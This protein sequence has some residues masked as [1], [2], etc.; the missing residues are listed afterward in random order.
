M[1]LV[2]LSITE[3]SIVSIRCRHLTII[4]VS[5]LLLQGEPLFGSALVRLQVRL[6]TLLVDSR[7]SHKWLIWK[8]TN[9]LRLFGC[10]IGKVPFDFTP[11]KGFRKILVLEKRVA[12]G[13]C[14]VG[15]YKSTTTDLSSNTNHVLRHVVLSLLSSHKSWL[16]IKIGHVLQTAVHGGISS[17]HVPYMFTYIFRI[18]R[19]SFWIRHFTW[20]L[21]SDWVISTYNLQ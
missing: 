3:W 19:I 4:K 7:A 9:P 8:R 1:W 5:E 2:R 11:F 21:R 15:K 13:N 18:K 16:R 14:I 10:G 17:V 12:W 20:M 6:R